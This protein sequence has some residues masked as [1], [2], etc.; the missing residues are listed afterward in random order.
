MIAAVFHHLWQSTL[1]AAVAGLLA[2]ALRNN[3]AHVRHWI[4]LIASLKFLV[5]FAVLTSLG[6]RLP[7]PAAMP[8]VAAVVEGIGR[9]FDAREIGLV[10]P[11][12]APAGAAIPPMLLA[13]VWLCGFG[14]VLGCW[15]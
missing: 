7:A 15:F 3:R 13:A 4:W 11:V 6:G 5:P 1:F 8:P 14:A 9:T 2:L 12:S 10:I